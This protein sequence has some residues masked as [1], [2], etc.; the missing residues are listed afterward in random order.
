MNFT[1]E[2]TEI[3]SKFTLGNTNNSIENAHFQPIGKS[4]TLKST[5]EVTEKIFAYKVFTVNW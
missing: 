1:L 2:T 4:P 3:S 5:V